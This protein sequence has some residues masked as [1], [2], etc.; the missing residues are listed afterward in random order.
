MQ[1]LITRADTGSQR[2][3]RRIPMPMV[4]PA[5]LTR[6]DAGR[7]ADAHIARGLDPDVR[8]RAYRQAILRGVGNDTDSV[9][10]VP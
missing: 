9:S 2:P 7:A 1:P 8:N 3:T 5:G 6:L 10:I 4:P